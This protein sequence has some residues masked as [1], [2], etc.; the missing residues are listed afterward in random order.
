MWLKRIIVGSAL[1]E[2]AR[3]VHGLLTGRGVDPVALKNAAYDRQAFAVMRRCLGRDSTCVDVGCHEGLM[4]REMLRLA[5]AGRHHAFEPIPELYRK[6]C[7]AF[8]T[9]TVHGVA[10]SDAAGEAV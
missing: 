5:P 4:L 1:E 3:R 10:L 6:L 9:V 8:P 2:P 7:V